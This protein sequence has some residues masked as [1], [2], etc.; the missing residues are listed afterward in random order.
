MLHGLAINQPASWY[1]LVA[2]STNNMDNRASCGSLSNMPDDVHF[3]AKLPTKRM[4][5]DCL[6]TDQA[7]R[8]LV[9][10]P[11][12]K[13]TWDIAGG[14]VERDESPRLAAQR[15]VREELGL[16]VEPGDLLAVDWLSQSGDATEMVAFLFDG[17][18]LTPGDIDKIV[19]DP[20]E[21]R[22]FRFVTLDEAERLLDAEQFMRVAAG[23]NARRS[24]TTEYLENGSPPTPISRTANSSTRGRPRAVSSRAM[25]GVQGR[26]A[27]LAWYRTDEAAA[28]VAFLHGFSDSAQCWE[29]LVRA[30]PGIRALAIDARG[31]GDSGLPEEPFDYI[32]HRDDAALVLSSQPRDGGMIVVGHSMGAMSAAHLAAAE[33]G[34]VRAVVLEDPPRGER[35]TDQQDAS[36]SMPTWLADARALDLPSRIAKCRSDEPDW[37]DDELEPWA[38]SKAQLNPHLF[39]LPFQEAAPLTEFLAAITC[40]VLLIHGDTERGSLISTEYA[41]R[42]AEAAAGEFQAAHIAGAGHSVRRDNRPQYVAALTAFLDRHG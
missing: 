4:A 28:D 40:P 1:E 41:E 35:R 16:N 30:L 26:T 17:G 2:L 23:L 18:V 7:S 11:P 21:T 32:R 22:R 3:T 37:S 6:F 14:V 42:C 24:G 38:V 9:L 10:E 15:E 25:F 33:P 20:T 36:F 8:L 5:A 29:P 31:H 12:Y 19:I 13:S 39:D 34:L 27:H